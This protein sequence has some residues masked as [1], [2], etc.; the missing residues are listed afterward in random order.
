MK[1]LTKVSL[2]LWLSIFPFFCYGKIF[3]IDTKLGVMAI[4]AKNELDFQEAITYTGNQLFFADET[5]LQIV[6]FR[7]P[8]VELNLL[9]ELIN[10]FAKHSTNY[11][12]EVFEYGN[13]TIT[14]FFI[15]LSQ[16][17]KTFVITE[18]YGRSNLNPE[19]RQ[20][21][22]HD[23]TY[24]ACA[25]DSTQNY[26]LC[27]VGCGRDLHKSALSRHY[28]RLHEHEYKLIKDRCENGFCCPFC[29]LYISSFRC[30]TRHIRQIHPDKNYLDFL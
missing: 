28:S 16:K 27:L 26:A 25:S 13:N 17:Q 4:T 19:V 8:T 22:I 20:D 7:E 1:K 15:S 14:N 9:A 18:E 11:Q 12:Y 5:A 30:L 6:M 3:F 2:I 10:W 24:S 21:S 29:N 23:F